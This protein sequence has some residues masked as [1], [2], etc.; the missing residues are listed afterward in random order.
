MLKHKM[1]QAFIDEKPSE[2]H[3]IYSKFIKLWNEIKESNEMKL[4]C[5]RTWNSILFWT[6]CKSNETKSK[7]SRKNAL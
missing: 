5:R 6:K 4:R 1:N 2:K 3:S 7:I